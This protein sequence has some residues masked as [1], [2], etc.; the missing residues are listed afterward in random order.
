MIRLFDV[1]LSI[2]G[3][4]ISL[5]L[6]I[7]LLLLGLFQTGSPLFY[8]VRLGHHLRPFTL[9]K[10]RTMRIGTPALPSHLVH[11]SATTSTGNFL[12]RTKLD[13]LPQLWNVLRGEMS[14]VGPRPCLPNQEKLIQERLRRGVFNV[15]PGITGYAQLMGID[16]STPERLAQVEEQMLAD[17]NV[18]TY[19]TCIVK[20][21]AGKG[22]GDSVR[23]AR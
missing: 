5:P 14:F 19:F 18:L 23:R 11:E 16:M 3:L 15:K 4:I 22:S 17:L 21:L 20:T 7:G 9:V 13:E 2:A 12:R 6:L 10:F 8:Q 1:L